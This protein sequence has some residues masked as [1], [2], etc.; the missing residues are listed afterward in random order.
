MS[1]TCDKRGGATITPEPQALQ[2][3][4]GSVLAVLTAARENNHQITRTKLVKLLY[5]ADLAAVEAGGTAFTGA[6]WRWDHYGP[7]DSAVR[8]A[9]DVSV[10]SNI[11]DRDDQ[12]RP[13]DYGTCHLKLAIDIDDPLPAPAMAVIRRVVKD[14]GGKSAGALQD[15]SY[16]TPPM[17]EATAADDRQVLL[18][19]SLARR[20]KQAQVLL[21]R[22][23]RL[24]DAMPQRHDDPGVGDE[25]LEEMAATAALRGRVNAEELG[26]R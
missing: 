19:L 23:R 1:T 10:D 8:R 14:H 12:I 11:V 21:D 16:S 25:L 22:H 17:V 2:P 4:L 5:L 3:L 9:E 13:F 26:D 15:L 7:Y 6:T 18:D 24:R 20:A